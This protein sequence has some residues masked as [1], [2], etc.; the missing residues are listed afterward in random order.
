MPPEEQIGDSLLTSS[1]G[2]EEE[3][4]LFSD[5]SKVHVF[6]EGAWKLVGRGFLK[7]N[8]HKTTKKSRMILRGDTGKLFINANLFKQMTVS[9][10]DSSVLFSLIVD[11]KLKKYTAKLKTADLAQSLCLEIEKAVANL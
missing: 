1:A 4:S 11:G 6:D 8:Q 3:S 7:I 5:V 2:E 9:T 10:K